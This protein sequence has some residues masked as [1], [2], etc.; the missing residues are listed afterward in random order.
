MT[1]NDLRIRAQLIS[2]IQIDKAT[3]YKWASEEILNIAADYFRAGVYTKETFTTTEEFELY[4]PNRDL[5]VVDKLIDKTTN[6]RV[7]DY[8][9]HNSELTISVPSTYE[10]RYYSYPDVPSTADETIDMPRQYVVPIQF[11]LAARIRARLF[12]QNDSNA[13]SFM[14]EYTENLKKADITTDVQRNRHNRMPPGR[15]D[16]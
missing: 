2:S 9:I 15:R 7:T 8:E 4:E 10:L 12:G 11:F 1:I 5:L 13:V 14:T 3:A 16:L 6:R